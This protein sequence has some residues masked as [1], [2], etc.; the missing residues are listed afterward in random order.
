LVKFLWVEDRLSLQVHPSDEFARAFEPEGSGKME[1]WYVV[2]AETDARV[3]R[4]VLPGTTEAEFREFL[5]GDKIEEC[6]N[7][8][9]VQSG[10]V[11]F[12]PPGTIH[13]A[14]GGILLFE[15]QQASDITYRLSDWGRTDASGRTRKTE[16]ERAMQ[17][18]DMQSIGVSKLKPTRLPGFPYRRS[19]LIR[20][21]KF[22]M[23]L[24]DLPAGKRARE[25]GDPQRFRA[26]TVL[27]GGGA[28]HYGAELKKSEPFR[29]G[30]TFLIPAFMGDYEL[31]AS[32]Q[33]S[34]ISSTT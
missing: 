33:T 25:K 20:C 14:Y 2:H 6:V 26:L 11:I 22:T 7:K 28:I 15:L 29:T 30:Q 18:M 19:L 21:E 3:M 34:V 13:S 10:D 16:P 32:R 8:L 24:L 27:Q 17:A 4:G 1:A 31:R 23:E 12:I 5:S 9:R